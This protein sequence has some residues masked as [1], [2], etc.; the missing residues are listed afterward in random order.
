M[1]STWIHITLP[2]L[3]IADSSKV[4]TA[5][6]LTMLSRLPTSLPVFL[7]HL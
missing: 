6:V 5:R 7:F 2:R 1:Q 4:Q 3:F